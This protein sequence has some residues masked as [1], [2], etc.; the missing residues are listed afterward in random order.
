MNIYTTSSQHEHQQNEIILRRHSVYCSVNAYSDV[1][2]LCP[3]I[4]IPHI[5]AFFFLRHD[6]EKIV[7]S[8]YLHKSHNSKIKACQSN[9]ILSVA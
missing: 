1:L 5:A 9:D 6:Q 2:K 3:T 4:E 8:Q 7:I